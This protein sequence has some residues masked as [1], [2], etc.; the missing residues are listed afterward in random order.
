MHK[1]I[2]KN[3]GSLAQWCLE[4]RSMVLKTEAKTGSTWV[5]KVS[6]FYSA[7]YFD[8]NK[9]EK[10]LVSEDSDLEDAKVL[11]LD[12]IELVSNA[13]PDPEISSEQSRVLRL[14]KEQ[15]GC[16]GNPAFLMGLHFMFPKP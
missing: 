13:L 12:E 10:V 2:L 8:T 1:I 9:A 4:D 14:S 5:S 15:V 11:T 6:S 16:K 3:A 7:I